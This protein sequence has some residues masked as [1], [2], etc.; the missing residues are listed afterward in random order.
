MIQHTV[1]MFDTELRALERQVA[2][3]GHL[4]GDQIVRSVDALV[5][6]DREL[7]RSVIAGD[8]AIDHLQ[9]EIDEKAVALIARRQPMAADLREIIGAIRI[10]ND[11][12]RVGDLAESIAKRVLLIVDSF[13][14]DEPIRQMRR[15]VELV[16]EQVRSVLQSYEAR[17]V[18]A[19]MEVWRKDREVDAL[20]SSLFRELLTYMMEDMRSISYC[21]HLLFCIK[22]VERI[23]D[24]ATNIAETVHYIVK[25][26]PLLEERPKVDLTSEVMTPQA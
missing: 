17:D 6:K 4:A 9:Q 2:Q 16:L 7:A 3:M 12:E 26:Q 10:A 22:N 5:A 15:M 18:A 25:G 14:L 13:A 8:E 1:R 19:A 11:L 23:G 24:H 21:A 20:N